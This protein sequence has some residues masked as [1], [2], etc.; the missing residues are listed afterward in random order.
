MT[1]YYAKHVINNVVINLFV[2]LNYFDL[3]FNLSLDL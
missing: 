2:K 3:Q 1:Y